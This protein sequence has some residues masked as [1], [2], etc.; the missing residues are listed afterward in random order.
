MTEPTKKEFT[1]EIAIYDPGCGF[2]L[3][4]KMTV[5]AFDLKDAQ[6]YLETKC[7]SMFG[8]NFKHR[9]FKKRVTLK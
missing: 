8:A 1:V 5:K 7:E 4:S 9:Y 3:T 6:A 2:E